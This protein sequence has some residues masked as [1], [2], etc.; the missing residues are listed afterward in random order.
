M[1]HSWTVVAVAAA[2]VLALSRHC[3]CRV[4]SALLVTRRLC[5]CATPVLDEAVLVVASGTG[6]GCCTAT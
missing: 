5:C 2:V 1:F 4:G 6:K 3:E